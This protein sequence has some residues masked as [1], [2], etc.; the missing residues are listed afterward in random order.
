MPS[1]TLS[2]K[3]GKTL[4]NSLSN[5]RIPTN[6]TNSLFID[7]TNA[8]PVT[9]GDTLGEI[10]LYLFHLYGLSTPAAIKAPFKRLSAALRA[11]NGSQRL[12]TMGALHLF[13]LH[14]KTL[15]KTINISFISPQFV[16]EFLGSFIRKKAI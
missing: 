5:N 11:N 13:L 9:T 6:I 10:G 2:R 8:V 3:K 4:S 7:G 15:Y 16:K 1:L 12:T 14:M